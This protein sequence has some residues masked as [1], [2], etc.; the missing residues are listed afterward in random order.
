MARGGGAAHGRAGG[1]TY[2]AMSIA[3]QPYRPQSPDQENS[4]D[5][6]SKDEPCS[7]LGEESN[8]ES[9]NGGIVV[10]ATTSVP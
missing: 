2:V 10:D 6:D 1:L 9:F 3:T 8:F 7:E 5:I 4:T